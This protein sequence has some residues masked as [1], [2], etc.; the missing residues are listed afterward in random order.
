MDTIVALSSPPGASARAILR[1]SGP[2]ALEIGAGL[3]GLP[4]PATRTVERGSFAACG[5]AATA[6]LLAMP[7]PR[8]YTREDVAE[9]HLP[10]AS[11]ISREALRRALSGGAREAA[12]GEFTRRAVE[13]GRLTLAQAEGVMA[14]IRARDD[15]SLRRA[16]ERLAGRGGR[17]LGEAAERLA[18]L[19]ADVE[20][21][22]DFI[23]HD[24]PFVGAA[25]VAARAGSL[26]AELARA[27]AGTSPSDDLPRFVLSGPPNAG[28]TSL[29]NA[30]TGA[31]ALVSAA[32]GTTRD[33]LEAEVLLGSVTVRISDSPGDAAWPPG[34]DADASERGRMAR[35]RADFV[36]HVRDGTRPVEFLPL[37]PAREI[38]V[39]NKSDLGGPARTLP[40]R[41]WLSVSARTGAGLG[42]LRARLAMMARRG[43]GTA[44]SEL[45]ARESDAARRAAEACGRARRAAGEGSP[46]EFVALELREAMDA[47]GEAAGEISAEDVLD[48]VFRKFCIGK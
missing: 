28:K 10:G 24:V 17:V 31:R 25:E 40:H 32:R 6:T 22:I 19:A 42:R 21:S 43:S 18:A 1:L 26:E 23:E 14:V 30:L 16:T 34:P 36:V 38:L 11:P 46:E 29:F 7:A 27:S 45:S 9:V 47:L 44:D 3:C 8:S 35:D 2:R 48:R 15:A 12:P 41:Q 4:V 37:D 5:A 20:A 13:N 33:S 39:L